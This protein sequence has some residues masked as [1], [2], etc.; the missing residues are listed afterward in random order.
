MD[1]EERNQD[2]IVMY[3]S[4]LSRALREHDDARATAI[5]EPEPVPEPEPEPEPGP[6]PAPAKTTVLGDYIYF[7]NSQVKW[8]KVYAYWWQD[9]YSRT[10]DLED[11]DYGCVTKVNDDGTTGYEPTKFP[12]TAMTQI[13]GTDV[14]QARVPFGATWII[15]NSGKSDEQIW[16]GETGY[17]TADLKFDPT[18]N[19][20]QIYV[21]DA[22]VEPKKGRAIEKTKFKYNEGEWK[23]YAGDFVPETLGGEKP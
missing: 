12:G 5:Y 9:D 2:A 18:A 1:V 3:V 14:W 4:E 8:E 6:E 20:G 21:I 10:Y 16:A 15:F 19:A 7:D 22:S 13:P 17:Q 23:D 11:N